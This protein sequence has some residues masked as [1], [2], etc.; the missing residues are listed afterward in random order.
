MRINPQNGNASDVPIILEHFPKGGFIVVQR[1]CR[2]T[3]KRFMKEEKY[4][5]VPK[6][7]EPLTIE[8][9]LH[10]S[11][12]DVS[13]QEN[14]KSHYVTG[15]RLTDKSALYIAKEKFASR[16]TFKLDLEFPAAKKTS[17]I[18]LNA[19]INLF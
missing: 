2:Q 3:T 4:T 18:G 12:I 8:K 13:F 1:F 14:V 10:Y 16:A 11:S 15:L 19:I 7:I 5:F 6:T 17:V 9:Y